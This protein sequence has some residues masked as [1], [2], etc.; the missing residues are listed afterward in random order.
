[1]IKKILLPAGGYGNRMPST[2][3]PKHCKPLIKAS[4]GR[5]MLE[6]TLARIQES[7]VTEKILVVTRKELVDEMTIII[8]KMGLNNVEI[9]EDI[10]LRG[11]PFVALVYADELKND[12]FGYICGHAPLGPE[13]LDAVINK[14]NTDEEE[15]VMC[16]STLGKTKA[17]SVRA[18]IDESGQIKKMLVPTQHDNDSLPIVN[19]P[20]L[21]TP[22]IINLIRENPDL[23]WQAHLTNQLDHHTT[24]YGT[25]TS[26][27]HEADTIEDLTRTFAYIEKTAYAP[28]Y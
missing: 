14:P 20:Y 10:Y 21:L 1:M 5:T 12:P 18:V 25:I 3:N 22:D 2:L 19:S 26:Y 13:F 7:R 9:F 23:G 6:H 28:V 4:D 17:K 24:I 16:Y 11:T 8:R 15:S 27:P